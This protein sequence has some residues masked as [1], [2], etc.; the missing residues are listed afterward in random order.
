MLVYCIDLRL[1]Q[2]VRSRLGVKKDYSAGLD[3]NKVVVGRFWLWA[4]VQANGRFSL[5]EDT[6]TW[7]AELRL[8]SV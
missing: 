5:V 8:L 2:G 7:E 6:D 1:Q 3:V 4:G